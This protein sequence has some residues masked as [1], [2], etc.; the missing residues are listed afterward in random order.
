MIMKN[1]FK[2]RYIM[3]MLGIVLIASAMSSSAHHDI[4]VED[5]FVM[6]IGTED[7]YGSSPGNPYYIDSEIFLKAYDVTSTGVGSINYGL[8]EEYTVVNDPKDH[9][10]AFKEFLFIPSGSLVRYENTADGYVSDVDELY[11]D[12]GLPRALYDDEE[13]Y[14]EYEEPQGYE[15]EEKGFTTECD[16]DV[17]EG[18]PYYICSVRDYKDYSISFYL[19]LSYVEGEGDLLYPEVI[20]T[21][22]L[23]P[24]EEYDDGEEDKPED[25][26]EQDDEDKEDEDDEDQDDE[27]DDGDEEDDDKD[28]ESDDED[29][30]SDDEDEEDDDK[31]EKDPYDVNIRSLRTE[32]TSYSPGD[33]MTFSFSLENEGRDLNDARAHI[34]LYGIDNDEYRRYT[35]GP[36]NLIRD[37]DILVKRHIRLPDDISPGTYHIR[38]SMGDGSYRM[39]KHRDF[40]VE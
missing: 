38:L 19:L 3:I 9:A 32:E 17:D 18:L 8:V 22:K 13:R 4:L 20:V 35:V 12:T 36:F 21:N 25:D 28:E 5:V 15:N 6:T 24:V 29:E 1:I 10:N 11:F 37:D 34:M 40:I 27:S 31:V 30:E 16:F 14:F 23:W 26:D 7:E 33:E 2:S 39:V